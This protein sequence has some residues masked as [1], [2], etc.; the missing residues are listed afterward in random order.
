MGRLLTTSA[1]QRTAGLGP[2]G[3][4]L[5]LCPPV[6][7]A[8]GLLQRRLL[9]WQPAHEPEHQVGSHHHQ[10]GRSTPLQ[11]LP[12]RLPRPL[13]Q[14]PPPPVISQPPAGCA[15][16]C[17][18]GVRGWL[19]GARSMLPTCEQATPQCHAPT[20]AASSF[21]PPARAWPSPPPCAV[22]RLT[23]RPGPGWAAGRKPRA[24]DRPLAGSRSWPRLQGGGR[25]AGQAHAPGRGRTCF[26]LGAGAPRPHAGVSHARELC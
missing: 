23:G 5:Q 10:Q 16:A 24:R 2:W 18:P 7:Q 19:L 22:P 21:P 3:A 1:F 25:A 12:E 26:Q 13:L 9:P 14:P 20:K 6:A 15:P 8:S 11:P 4:T 17:P